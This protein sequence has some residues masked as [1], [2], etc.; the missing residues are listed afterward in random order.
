MARGSL[1]PIELHVE[2]FVLALAGA[3]LL[4]SAWAFLIRSPNTVQFENRRVGPAGLNEAIL[5]SARRLEEALR[6]QTPE[7]IRVENYS[8]RLKQLQDEGLF[9]RHG[10]SGPHLAS[11]LPVLVRLGT[12]IEVP[13]LKEDEEAGGNITLVTPLRPDPPAV[14]TGRS[15]ARRV[16]VTLGAAEATQRGPAAATVEATE[17]PWVTL[18]TWFNVDAQREE[19]IKAGYAAYRARVYVVGLDV[20]RQEMLS[21]GEFSEWKDVKSGAMPEITIPDPVFDE[22]T[23][24]LLNS[25][26]IERAF[27]IVRSEQ[28]TLMQPE[29]LFVEA[30]DD[31]ENP[32]PEFRQEEE[33]QDESKPVRKPDEPKPRQPPRPPSRPPTPGRGA[34]DP[35]RGGGSDVIGGGA[36]GRFAGAGQTADD[37]AAQESKR[38]SEGRRQASKDMLEATKAFARKEYGQARDLAQRVVGNEFATAA[39]RRRAEH[40]IK[41]IDKAQARQQPGTTPE[42]AVRDP[43]MAGGVDVIGEDGGVANPRLG[44]GA[45]PRSPAAFSGPVPQQHAAEPLV[46]HP[47]KPTVPAVWFHDDSVESGKTYR[48]RARIKL[49]NRYVG[50]MKALANPADAKKTVIVGEWSL[51][52]E[53]IT[54]TPST[55]FFVAGSAPGKPSAASV[56]VWKWRQ[57]MW[58]KHR[59]EVEVGDA[60]GE[61]RKVRIPGEFNPET[62]QELTVDVD[63]HTG[64][65]VLDIRTEPVKVRLPGRGGQFRHNETR[66][67]VLTYLDPAD[68]Q[69][70]ERVEAFDRN[71]PIR[72]R[73]RDELIE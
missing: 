12:R 8:R 62:G 61:S 35:R 3:F 31:W 9:A 47:E 22:N 26:Q 43:R 73:L 50:R 69:A 45:G 24:A 71:D 70:K 46:V 41:K 36:G 32:L 37:S 2:K 59:V 68:G 66:S 63:F 57:G 34:T 72:A 55:Y 4:Y 49:W 65:V 7:P 40:L 6:R 29:F 13:G 56:E 14:A 51:P 25:E 28:K 20:Q 54:V 44:G 23:G 48:Y 33:E 17:T 5:E 58:L 18:A 27:N 21:N 38:K 52:S 30:G 60:I 19:M 10:E 11:E 64:A 16:P 15:L 53:P 39:T 42:P 67:I 1:N